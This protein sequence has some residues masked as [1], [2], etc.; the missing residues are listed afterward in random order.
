MKTYLDKIYNTKKSKWYQENLTYETVSEE[1]NSL[2]P[3]EYVFT[4]NSEEKTFIKNLN[5]FASSLKSYVR[6]NYSE[7]SDLN[8]NYNSEFRYEQN[9]ILEFFTLNI[10]LFKPLIYKTE[11]KD[12]ELKFLNISP[13]QLV[14]SERDFIKL[15]QK[16]IENNQDIFDE[17]YFLRNPS[18]KGIGFFETKNFYPDFILWTIKDKKQTISFIDPKGLIMVD[19]NDEKL[20]LFAS[21]KDIEK[22]LNEKTN[23][24]I[25]LF[26]F[27]VTPTSSDDLK[28]KGWT[29]TKQE[30]NSENILFIDDGEDLVKDI[31]NKI[32]G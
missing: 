16:Y 29:K 9:K 17:I 1:D 13:I 6:E 4:I 2:V 27:I 15:I 25:K 8:A 24:N 19:S 20:K 11:T 31:F 28:K 18:R 21:I 32:S 10:H 30:L 22:E 26:S 7:E 5:D 3:K 14:K 23:L 12:N